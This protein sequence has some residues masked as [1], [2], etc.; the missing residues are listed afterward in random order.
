LVKLSKKWLKRSVIPMVVLAVLGTYL[1]LPLS[2]VQAEEKVLGQ[3]DYSSIVMEGSYYAYSNNPVQYF[4]TVDVVP[5]TGK[6]VTKVVLRNK[7]TKEVV[8]ELPKASS[9]AYTLGNI[10]GEKISVTHEVADIWDGTWNWWR[11]STNPKVWMYD[12][13]DRYYFLQDGIYDQPQLNAKKLV[14]P[15]P[16]DSNAALPS[17]SGAEEVSDGNI[18]WAE[19]TKTLPGTIYGDGQAFDVSKLINLKASYE[20]YKKTGPYISPSNILAVETKSID[21]SSLKLTFRYKA[22]FVDVYTAEPFGSQGLIN[23]YHTAWKVSLSTEVYKYPQLEIVYYQEPAGGGSSSPGASSMPTPTPTTAPTT[24]DLEVVSL[25]YTPAVFTARDDVTFTWVFRNNSNRDWSNFYYSYGS[26]H[27]L[28]SGT[29][30]KGE[31]VTRTLTTKI[32]SPYTLTVKIDSRNEIAEFNESNNEKSVTAIPSSVTDNDPPEGRLKWFYQGTDRIA[33]TVVEGT[34]VDLKYVDVKDPDNDPVGYR[35]NF[36][37]WNSTFY[38]TYMANRYTS[39][40]GYDAFTNISTIGAV[41]NHIARGRLVDPYGGYTDLSASLTVIPPN[42]VAMCEVPSTTKSRRPLAAGAINANKSYSPLSRTIDHSRDE[43]TNNLPFYIN[44]TDT[45]T[46]ETVIL[47]KV[48]DNTGLASLNRDACSITVQPDLPP[49][50]KVVA[51]ALGIRGEDF[52]IVSESYSPDGDPIVEVLWYMRYDANNDGVFNDI[53]EPW[54]GIS[55]APSKYVFH[56]AKI[57]KY[58]FKIKV[59]EDYGKEAEAVSGIMDVINLAPEVSFDLTGSNPNPDQN[60]PQVFTGETIKNTWELYRTNTNVRV[61]RIPAYRWLTANGALI[62]G[63]G[64]NN[65]SYKTGVNTV[66]NPNGPGTAQNY[67]TPLNDNGWGRNGLSIYKAFTAPENGYSQPLWLPDA[68]GKPS[69]WADARTTPIV[70]D[71]TYLFVGNTTEKLYALNKSKIGRY[72]NRWE[73]DYQ[74]NNGVYKPYWLDGSP[75]DFTIDLSNVP[76]SSLVQTRTVPF[77]ENSNYKWDVSVKD[78]ISAGAAY[79]AGPYI[80]YTFSLGAAYKVYE[81]VDDDGS[82]TYTYRNILPYG[83]SFKATNA[84]LISCFPLPGETSNGAYVY[85]PKVIV[86]GHNLVTLLNTPSDGSG[87]INGYFGLIQ[88]E[89]DVKGNIVSTTYSDGSN[90]P[91]VMTPYEKKTVRWPATDTPVSFIP[92][93]YSVAACSF[94]PKDEAPYRDAEGNF[95]MYETKSCK[96][97]ESAITPVDYSMRAYPELGLG[98]YVAKYDPNY[99]LVWRA[100]TRGNLFF[101]TLMGY[102]TDYKDNVST[103]VVNSLNRTLVAKT[104]YVA[105]SSYGDTY[106][107]LNDLIDL[108]TGYVQPW[109]GPVLNG[110]SSTLKVD[111]WGNYISGN[112]ALNIYGQNVNLNRAGGAKLSGNTNP[113]VSNWTE[114]VSLSKFYEEFVGDGILLSAH[115]TN[116]LNSMGYNNPPSGS[117]V[118][119]IDKGPVAE[120]VAIQPRYDYGQFMSPVTAAD[121]EF[122]FS[123]TTEQVKVDS[124]Q[125]GFSFRMQDPTNRLAVEFDGNTISLSKYQWGA[126]YVLASNSYSLQDN[127]DY[128]VKIRT[129]G[130]KLSVWVNRVPYFVDVADG[131]FSAGR[132]GPFSDKSFVTFRG[133]SH[134]VYQETN[135]WGSDFA[136]LDEAAGVAQLNYDN[137]NFIDPEHDPMSGSFFWQY[138]HSPMFLNN[139]GVSP[140]NGSSHTS[141]LPTFDRV[142]RWEVNLMAKDDPA[143][144]PAYRYPDMTF[145]GYRKNSNSFKRAITVHRRPISVLNPVLNGNT[146]AWNDSSYDPDRF[147]INTGYAEPGYAD[148]RGIFERRYMAISPS[149]AQFNYMVT[150]L[151]EKGIWTLGLQ[152]KDEFGAWSFLETAQVEVAKDAN[153]KPSVILTNPAGTEDSPTYLPVNTNPTITWT[154]SDPDP[155]TLYTAYELVAE[156]ISTGIWGN[157]SVSERISGAK[158]ELTSEVNGSLFATQLWGNTATKY[159]VKI[160]VKDETEW[161]DW[162]NVGWF[163]SILPPSATLTFPLGTQD[164]PTYVPTLRPTITWNQDDP[165]SKQVISQEIN[166]WNENGTLFSN[167]V[168]NVAYA[169]YAKT[170]DNWQLNTDVPMGAKMRVAVRVKNSANVWSP[171]SNSGWFITN[172][173]P[174]A[175]MAV[176]DGS[177]YAPTMFNTLRPTFVWNQTDPDPGTVFTSFQIQ[178]TNAANTVTLLDSGEYWQ[179]SSAAT[180]S[181]QASAD[182]PAGQKLR[183]RARV[184][185]GHVWSDWSAQTWFYIN[186]APVADFTWTPSPVYEG[187]TISLTN[188]SY[189]PDGDIFTSHWTVMQPDGSSNFYDTTHVSVRWTQVGTYT[190]TLIVTDSYGDSGTITKTIQVQPLGIT[191]F[192][193]HTDTWNSNR[194]KFNAKQEREETG[195]HRNDDEFW[196]GEAFVLSANTTNTGT[197]TYAVSV[198]VIAEGDPIPHDWAWYHLYT[199]M[200]PEDS[201][202]KWKGRMNSPD[203]DRGIKME[204]LSD[205]PLDF[206]FEVTYSNGT[207]KQDVVRI[208]MRNKWTE[209]WQIHRAW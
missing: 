182:L 145:D 33:D 6:T 98:S 46:T 18:G 68:N 96:D 168:R 125:F 91:T 201:R 124:S 194:A 69:T 106:S 79:V 44:D 65:E 119:W 43:W 66:N 115:Q 48:Y 152:V 169:D 93:Q 81:S 42:P 137:I 87:V 19:S 41:G 178:V 161:S 136:I 56:P 188:A 85:K 175:S 155:N 38:K 71:K 70:S 86:K 5:D 199:E 50:A 177:E 126:R 26:M 114:I 12:L 166:V 77:Y 23:E 203:P 154:R 94:N 74:T 100:R 189:D 21:F 130:N 133:I 3:V 185:D 167:Q 40:D 67:T 99:K 36:S 172:R 109:T 200:E 117:S 165:N 116:N 141:A 204:Q 32:D 92:P 198:D 207:V 163:S 128:S 156:A 192:V 147:D 82:E 88:Q 190:V 193:G 164:N 10:G 24:D 111:A 63:A 121:A 123:F 112:G 4:T 2:V 47:E 157:V 180:G 49:I 120:A 162:S 110:M 202:V 191:G 139:G 151:E 158:A 196:A 153:R 127:K 83:C 20:Y 140:L 146:V 138:T 78:T 131:S 72:E 148:N 107:V 15:K 45:D 206:I 208:Y 132:F 8:R 197:S 28:Y 142:G 11:D 118:Y 14:L 144:E 171:W 160:R 51:P 84:E 102:V 143:P 95:Y 76:S 39:G 179:N 80:Y 37:E 90:N 27:Y 101:Y 195:V 89:T 34:P 54:T 205:G 176:P 1:A 35:M 187:D 25:S 135:I 31:S 174:A 57:G 113:Y 170:S 16:S 53:T 64:K 29:L 181:W 9:N 129:V 59:K 73:V 97:G 134:K 150:S 30:K 61:N 58:Q 103:M 122:S 159:R 149:G 186:R 60:M 105:P 184:F 22:R 17:F 52:D 108:D 104:L 13:G 75:Y 173:P 62:S 183:V 55:G 209:Y 7:A